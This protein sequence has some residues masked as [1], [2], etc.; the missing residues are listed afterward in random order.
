MRWVEDTP[1]EPS[2]ERSGHFIKQTR[3]RTGQGESSR[4]EVR[5]DCKDKDRKIGQK[6]LR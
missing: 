5:K 3:K 1:E 4:E 6:T 2:F